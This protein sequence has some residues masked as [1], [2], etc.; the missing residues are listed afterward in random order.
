MD[1]QAASGPPSDANYLADFPPSLTG[2][3]VLVGHSYGGAVISAGNEQ[4]EAVVHANGVAAR[5]G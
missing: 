1:R 4:I 2:P 5:R 3:I